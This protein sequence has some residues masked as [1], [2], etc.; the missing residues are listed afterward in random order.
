MGLSEDSPGPAIESR[1]KKKPSDGVLPRK[2]IPSQHKRLQELPDLLL[3]D[4]YLEQYPDLDFHQSYGSFLACKNPISAVVDAEI[5][6]YWALLST[7][8]TLLQHYIPTIIDSYRSA[9]RKFFNTGPISLHGH[10]S[11][12]ANPFLLTSLLMQHATAKGIFLLREEDRTD[13]Q[14]AIAHGS[15]RARFRPLA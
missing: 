15:Y 6:E 8:P 2:Q 13:K 3:G 10:V 11:D 5:A 12:A 9:F 7:T 4:L 1:H 14:L